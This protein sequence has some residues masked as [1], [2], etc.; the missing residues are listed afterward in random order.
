MKEKG[1]PQ[2]LVTASL[3]MSGRLDSNQR[4]PEPH[5]RGSEEEKP[6]NTLRFPH[7]RHST[8]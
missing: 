7:F 2:L 3:Q 4:P 1:S 5:L 8:V 6:R